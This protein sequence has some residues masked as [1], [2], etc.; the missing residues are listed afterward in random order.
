VKVSGTELMHGP[1]ATVW[2]ALTDPAVLV[3]AIPGCQRLER[4]GQDSYRF[5][6]EAGLA[7]LRGVY[8]GDVTLS[9]QQEPGSFRLTATAA[10]GPGTVSLSVRFR[11]T[12]TGDAS[13]ELAYDA[14]GDVSGMLASAGQRLVASVA[15]R[16]A[17]EFF[18]SVDN[19]LARNVAAPSQSAPA[20]TAD[21]QATP[22]VYLPSSRGPGR[23]REIVRDVLVGT[24]AA[25][26]G[27]A[28]G[29]VLGK[30]SSSDARAPSP[31]SRQRD[32]R[33]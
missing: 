24:A 23:E 9:D 28:I 13:T 20:G 14:D 6:I 32:G 15:R 2:A 30:R 5:T 25:L 16:M 17:G 33:D 11:L 22:Q 1:P 21:E 3:D 26:A 31:P 8:T 29:R 4:A 19:H 7:S 12:G 27:M 18:G 10:G